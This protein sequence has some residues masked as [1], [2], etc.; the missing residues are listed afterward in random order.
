MASTSR[1][2]EAMYWD[3]REH[4]DCSDTGFHEP[5]FRRDVY[6]KRRNALKLCNE[7]L[8]F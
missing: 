5:H 2:L 1:T 7:L 4:V 3:N 8:N 6:V